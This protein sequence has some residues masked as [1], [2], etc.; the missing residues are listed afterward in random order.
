MS[1]LDQLKLVFRLLD[2]PLHVFSK[3]GQGVMGGK[4]PSP[5]ALQR[6]VNAAIRPEDFYVCL[7]P[8]ETSRIKPRIE[9]IT[10]FKWWLLDFDPIENPD[11]P[12]AMV[13]VEDALK[14]MFGF[15]PHY[16]YVN[17]GRGR[18]L[19]IEVYGQ[20][21]TMEDAQ[22]LVKGCT[23][24]LIRR[25]G[26]DLQ[27]HGVRIDEACAEI[28]HLG[29]LPGTLNTKTG[30]MAAILSERSGW[31]VLLASDMTQYKAA[32]PEPPQ[33][34]GVVLPL[35]MAKLLWWNS[36]TPWNRNFIQMGVDTNIE[37]RHRR[38]TA[39]ARQLRDLEVDPE[40]A[41]EWLHDGALAC[42]P[43]LEPE[44]IARLFKET[45]K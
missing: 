29:R 2:A 42:K 7:N 36:L 6:W 25:A 38:A 18:Q 43:R 30:Q 40:T 33:E 39:A 3:S 5:E 10:A 13:K 28:S 41:K 32:P 19:W 23:D 17:S 31:Q 11:Y 26:V 12:A 22:L 1:Q 45:F 35:G 8:S 27:A 24:E 15:I 4:I 34:R 9:D 37:S 44:F 21:G 14:A 20:H 16:W